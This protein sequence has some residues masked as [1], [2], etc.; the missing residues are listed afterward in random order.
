MIFVF[1]STILF[2]IVAFNST[3]LK[4]S[5]YSDTTVE[6][7]YDFMINAAS[8]S[9]YK[10]DK[11]LTKYFTEA[12]IKRELEIV[13]TKSL[14]KQMMSDV[15]AQIDTIKEG[16]NKTITIPLKTFKDSL[17][18]LSHNLAYD[19]FKSIELCG[20]EKIPD[21][22]LN[23]L[24]TCIVKNVDFDLVSAPFSKKIE[25]SINSNIP[26]L[27][28][29][30]LDAIKQNGQNVSAVDFIK[31]LAFLRNLIYGVL[32]LI[33]IFIGFLFYKLF[34]QAMLYYGVAFMV[35]GGFGYLMSFSL[36]SFPKIFFSSINLKG[37]TVEIL[38][39]MD[40]LIGFFSAEVQ[41]NSL[42]F[43]A[44]GAVLIM[45]SLFLKKNSSH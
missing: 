5:F 21:Q 11:L 41:K 17:L 38:A 37:Q 36:D 29:F 7:G 18:T 24:P 1:F 42:A 30:N 8:S 45:A 44:I 20:D 26:E 14:Y 16:D 32:L 23:G 22:D 40:Y 33:L 31:N 25:S 28:R 10:S 2:T 27:L 3:F 6:G 34:Y 13:F 12:D 4:P 19:I 35:S 9:I 39:M 15:S 43:L